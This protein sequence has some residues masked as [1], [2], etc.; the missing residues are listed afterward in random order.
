M[1]NKSTLVILIS[2][3]VI[4]L[5]VSYLLYTW[6]GAGIDTPQLGQQQEEQANLAPD[7]TVYDADGNEVKLSDFVGKPTVV[8]F[9]ASWCGP[10][11]SEMPAFQEK[12]EALGDQVNFLM[13][14]MTDGNRET[15]DKASV[16]IGQQGYTFPVY[17]DT[18]S[19]AAMTYQVYSIPSTYFIGA[20]GE[21]VAYATGAIDA[22]TLQAGL[23]MILP[24][25]ENGE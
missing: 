3:L 7:F 19:D 20:S 1:K 25:A 21:A 17:F 13:V 24:P 2:G 23:D 16:Y 5:S 12:Y 14:N 10:C 4:L 9:W 18:D 8:N 11:K 22:A 6:L 15:V